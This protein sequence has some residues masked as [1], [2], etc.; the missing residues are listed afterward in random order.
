MCLYIEVPK[1]NVDTFEP[2]YMHLHSLRE[3]SLG[4]WIR[5]L[6]LIKD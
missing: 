2:Y 6:I 3:D 4:F 5:N 1:D